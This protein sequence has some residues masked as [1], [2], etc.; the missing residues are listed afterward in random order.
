MKTSF[1]PMKQINEKSVKAAFT[2]I[3]LLVVIAIIA[4]LAAML[5]PALGAAREKA[6]RLACISNN[7]QLGTALNMYS[8][9]NHDYMPWPNWGNSDSY[10]GVSVVGW[11]YDANA[12]GGAAGAGWANS[13]TITYDNYSVEQPLGVKSGV[14]WQY[15]QNPKVFVCPDDRPNRNDPNWT[16]R[17]DKLST[18]VMN[19]TAGLFVPNTPSG[20][21]LYMYHTC[22]RSD[23]W[24]ESCIILWEPDAVLGGAFS[25]NDG[26][27]YPGGPDHPNEGLSRIHG[28]GGV[29]LTVGGQAYAMTYQNFIALSKQPWPQKG[30]F[31]KGKGLLYWNV[32]RT[33]GWY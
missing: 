19:G 3:E 17:N 30:E 26:S 9:D 22:K 32:M 23:I 31:T 16:G 8:S 6:R 20:S 24:S 2:L 12:T 33:D 14:L 5:L 13:A 21:H 10:G 4:I 1:K 11:L 29:V 18:Y 27:S 28:L 7:R 25:Y 15:A